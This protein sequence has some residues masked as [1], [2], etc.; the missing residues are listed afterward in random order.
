VLLLLRGED[1]VNEFTLTFIL[2]PI[3]L[4][5]K[6]EIEKKIETFS[7]A[8]WARGELYFGL[9]FPQIIRGQPV[10][11]TWLRFSVIVFDCRDLK[12][13][14]FPSS[15]FFLLLQLTRDK[16]RAFG[17]VALPTNSAGDHYGAPIWCHFFLFS[18]FK[19]ESKF[20]SSIL[21][22]FLQYT[23]DEE[24]AFGYVALPPNSAGGHYGAPIWCH[25][26]DFRDLNKNR[27]P[28]GA[29]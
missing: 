28:N 12:K 10:K 25:F 18:R 7:C 3:T 17:Y 13:S 23:R 15:I 6:R 11:A 27:D 5:L 24:R 29:P 19:H 4:G 1:L 8:S 14:T 20:P 16:E 2:L 26:F 22:L 21:F 9:L